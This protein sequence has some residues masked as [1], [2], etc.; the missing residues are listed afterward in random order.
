MYYNLLNN[1]SQVYFYIFGY[2]LYFKM[3]AFIS[4]DIEFGEIT[5]RAYRLG[6]FSIC[7]KTQQKTEN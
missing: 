2:F 1:V 3:N 6:T 5:L 4:L 7:E